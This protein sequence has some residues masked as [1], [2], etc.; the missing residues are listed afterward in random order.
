MT[1]DS[2]LGFITEQ[3]F[4]DPVSVMRGLATSGFDFQFNSCNHEDDEENGVEGRHDHEGQ[5][6]LAKD[7]SLVHLANWLAMSLNVSPLAIHPSEIVFSDEETLLEYSDLRDVTL[8]NA[9]SRFSLIQALNSKLEDLLK[10][11]DFR[12]DQDLSSNASVIAA[13]RC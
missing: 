2:F 10:L 8:V 11:T 9:R 7:S 1:R 6:S 4:N 3:S 5:W 13:A 12:P